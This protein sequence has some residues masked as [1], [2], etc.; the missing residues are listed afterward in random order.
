[1]LV[2]KQRCLAALHATGHVVPLLSGCAVLLSR[3]VHVALLQVQEVKELAALRAAK[4]RALAQRDVQLQQLEAL[5]HRI[6]DEQAA[7]KAEGALIR[8]RA[9]EEAE[10]LKQKVRLAAGC[11]NPD[12]CQLT[13]VTALC[14]SHAAQRHGAF[15][16]SQPG[17][18]ILSTMSAYFFDPSARGLSRRLQ[19]RATGS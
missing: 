13:P 3:T 14:C 5:K 8:Q 11:M 10:Q 19:Q 15:S 18:I 16:S 17:G 4:Q 12:M 9:L 1:M 6:L 2:L 7:D